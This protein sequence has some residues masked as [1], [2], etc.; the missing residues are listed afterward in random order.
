MDGEPIPCRHGA[1]QMTASLRRRKRL[2]LRGWLPSLR[3]RTLRKWWEE[4]P[5]REQDLLCHHVL[6]SLWE[7]RAHLPMSASNPPSSG[8]GDGKR[9]VRLSYLN[10]L[11]LLH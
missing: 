4:P 10:G 3:R 1:V 2:A 5:S 8:E 11:T 7:V 9:D 6:T